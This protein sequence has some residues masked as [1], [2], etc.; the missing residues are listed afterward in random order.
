MAL[1]QNAIVTLAETKTQL[2]V[3]D[4]SLDATIETWINET[5]SIIEEYCQRKFVV[6][7]ISNEIH[8]GDGGN[9]L[10]PRYFPI[11][12]LSTED[13]PD[14][15]QKLKALQYRD[16]PDSSWT[17]IETNINHIFL[18][19]NKPYI[20]L[21][22]ATFYLGKQNIK[23]SY[24]AGYSTVP[25]EVKKVALEMVQIWYNEH[26]GGGDTLGKQGSTQSQAGGNFNVTWN[27]VHQRWGKILDKYRVRAIG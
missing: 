27:D 23:I 12:Q 18:D 14:E 17:D 7:S 1:N 26:K 5:S 6:Q 11:V 25:S 16:S 10:Y 9:I 13:S 2:G 20:E 24:K 3:E 15:T 4:S 21:Y 22:D 8:D 19:T